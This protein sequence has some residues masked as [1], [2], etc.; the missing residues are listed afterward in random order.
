MSGPSSCQVINGMENAQQKR[1]Y[2]FFGDTAAFF[3]LASHQFGVRDRG[4]ASQAFIFD[5]IKGVAAEV[6]GVL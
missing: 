3:N 2:Q 1:R 6:A 4:E 5:V